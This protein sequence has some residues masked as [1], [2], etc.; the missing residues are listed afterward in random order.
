MFQPIGQYSLPLG[1]F[2]FIGYSQTDEKA[3]Y[4]F[5][6]INV[7]RSLLTGL[8]RLMYFTPPEQVSKFDE[9]VLCAKRITADRS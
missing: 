3:I 9:P 1:V 4:Q 5:T 8:H 2:L 7:S 6:H